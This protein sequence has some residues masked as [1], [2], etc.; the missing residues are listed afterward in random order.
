MVRKRPSKYPWER[1]TTELKDGEAWL[2]V[3][4]KEYTCLSESFAGAVRK[5]A[6]ERGL[7][8]TVVTFPDLVL[9][10]FF[11]GNGY[12]MPNMKALPVVR[13]FLDKYGRRS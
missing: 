1:W 7:K 8:V 2:C 9:F 3:R 12:L 10:R 5:E 4:F 13:E 11:D 6:A